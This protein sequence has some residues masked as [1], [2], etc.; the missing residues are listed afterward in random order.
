[1]QQT[2]ET[3]MMTETTAVRLPNY[4]LAEVKKHA[5]SQMRSVPKQIEHDLQLVRAAIDNPDLPIDFIKGVLEA[6]RDIANG[7]FYTS[8]N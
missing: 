1:M 7:N 2:K 4:L 8:L 5:D 3:D 6:K